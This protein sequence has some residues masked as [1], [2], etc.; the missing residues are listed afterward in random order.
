MAMKQFEEIIRRLEL[1]ITQLEKLAYSKNVAL[2]LKLAGGVEALIDVLDVSADHWNK[3]VKA[4][5]LLI[6]KDP[7]AQHEMTADNI[8]AEV[9]GA[10]NVPML[11]GEQKPNTPPPTL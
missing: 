8:P 1:M 2:G 3:R 11:L 7:P 6:P 5:L 10:V 9:M 4:A